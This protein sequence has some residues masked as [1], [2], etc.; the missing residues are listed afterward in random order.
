MN[1]DSFPINNLPSIIHRSHEKLPQDPKCTNSGTPSVRYYIYMNWKGE[2]EVGVSIR[3]IIALQKLLKRQ[4]EINF[5]LL[6]VA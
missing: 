4:S 3:P 6:E 5:K 1:D 2:R